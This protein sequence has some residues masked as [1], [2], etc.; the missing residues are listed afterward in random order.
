[1]REERREG[2]TCAV[3]LL[4][5][6]LMYRGVGG[7]DSL[8]GLARACCEARRRVVHMHTPSRRTKAHSG[9]TIYRSLSVS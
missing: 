1:M 8:H 2:R 5:E 3:G 7:I 4:V 9:F 6:V